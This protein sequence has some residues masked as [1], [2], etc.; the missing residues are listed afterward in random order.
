MTKSLLNLSLC[1]ACI[2][3][4]NTAC[5]FS[6]STTTVKGY[7]VDTVGTPIPDAKILFGGTLSEV[8]TKSDA[9]G[10]FTITAK[11][12]PT[13]ILRLNVTKDGYGMMEKVEFPGFAAPT[14]DIKVKM[15][16]ILG[17]IPGTK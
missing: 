7:V 13:Q 6:T 4:L 5:F 16:H 17:R 3:F 12:R 11:H 9:K 14:D 8:E 10:F 15:I 2:G 1:L